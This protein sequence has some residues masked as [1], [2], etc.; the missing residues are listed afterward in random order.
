MTPQGRPRPRR[1]RRAHRPR[2]RR[3]PSDDGG[4]RRASGVAAKCARAA[5]RDRPRMKYVDLPLGHRPRPR[6]G[7]PRRAGAS[8]GTSWPGSGC[9]TACRSATWCLTRTCCRWSRSASSTSTGPGP[10]RWCRAPC[11]VGT[12]STSDRAE[13][14]TVYPHIR[15]DVD[16]T[17]RKIRTPQG[18]GAAPGRRRH[19]HRLPAAVPGGLGLAGAARAGL[20]RGRPR[21]QRAHHGRGVAPE[22][23]EGAA[24]RAAGT[25]RTARP[26]RRGARGDAH[27]G[28]PAGP[29][30]RRSGSTPRRRRPSSA[31]RSR[32]A[33]ESTGKPVPPED[34]MVAANTVDVPFRRNA[35]GVINLKKLQRP[36]G[37]QARGRLRRRWSRATSRSRCSGSPYRQVFG[38]PDERRAACGSTTST[39]SV[40]THRSST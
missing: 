30:V 4:A 39:S 34:K 19:H 21:R 35:A 2:G 36:A 15:E 38:D 1:A 26:D 33:S 17:E 32:C 7:R 37:G 24:D 8:C 40:V 31:P 22:A 16:A 9:C 28:A 23:D 27:R 13:L 25:R 11:Q 20:L 18:G 12:I 6:R 5:R 3:R 10:T 29:A 14:E